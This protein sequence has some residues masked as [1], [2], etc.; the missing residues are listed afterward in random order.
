MNST[1]SSGRRADSCL[2]AS[3]T[4]TSWPSSM[5]SLRRTAT[6]SSEIRSSE[7]C[8]S[9]ICGRFSTGWPILVSFMDLD[10]TNARRGNALQIRLARIILRLAPSAEQIQQL[11]DNYARA[12][13]SKVFS[14]SY[15][16]DKPD[17]VFLPPELFNS[18]GPWVQ[19]GRQ[20]GKSAAPVHLHFVQGRSAFFVFMNLPGG[21]KAT[22]AYLERLKEFGDPLMPKPV[23]RNSRA[24]KNLPRFNPELPQFPVGTR[25]SLARE[26]LLIDNK[27]RITPTRLIESVHL[28]FIARYQN[29]SETF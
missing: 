16:P 11:P 27:G 12:L 24:A 6:S 3:T 19:L 23:D 15:N 2:L 10:P 20:G 7:P 18:D 14:T 13:A 9:T 5:N 22:L 26:M 1:R 4:S 28:G 17:T 21:R 25:V 8:F 29:R